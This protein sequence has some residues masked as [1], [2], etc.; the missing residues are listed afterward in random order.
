MARYVVNIDVE[1]EADNE[2]QAD[3]LAMAD[4]GWLID[5]ND[6]EHQASATGLGIRKA[7]M[8]FCGNAIEGE[9]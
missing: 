8:G 6:P 4:L 1:V 9:L 3:N 2:E 7:N 5:H